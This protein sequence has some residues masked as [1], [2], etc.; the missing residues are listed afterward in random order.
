MFQG[1]HHTAYLASFLGSFRI[2]S[3]IQ[4]DFAMSQPE[5]MYPILSVPFL[6]WYGVTVYA[7]LINDVASFFKAP[8]E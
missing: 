8:W 3:P 2:F 4:H 5:N 7:L 6:G 1:I